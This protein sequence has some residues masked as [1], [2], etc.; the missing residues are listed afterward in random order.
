MKWNKIVIRTVLG[1]LSS[2]IVYVNYNLDTPSV[3]ITGISKN[4]KLS[5]INFCSDINN[6]NYKKKNLQKLYIRGVL[7]IEI[8]EFVIH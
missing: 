8:L 4:M 6:E 1:S 7:I 3:Q 2:V 5:Y